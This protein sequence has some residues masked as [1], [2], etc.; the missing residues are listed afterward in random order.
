MQLTLWK[1]INMIQVELEFEQSEIFPSFRKMKCL[2]DDLV[3]AYRDE[4]SYW[5]QKSRH[6]WVVVGDRNTRFFHASVK[7]ARTRNG[8]EKLLGKDGNLHR[9]KASKRMVNVDYFTTLF[10]SSSPSNPA[11]IYEGFEKK[12]SQ[13]LSEFLISHVTKRD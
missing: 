9:S 8:L 3:K 12:I 11:D 4:E 2:Q 10:T 1:K 5:Q 7:G 6:K 13:S